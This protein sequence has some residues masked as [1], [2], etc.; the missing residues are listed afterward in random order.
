[1][2]IQFIFDFLCDKIKHLIFSYNL[3]S[4]QVLLTFDKSIL[5]FKKIVHEI[6]P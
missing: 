2:K 3:S 1:M 6:I 5:N 4:F